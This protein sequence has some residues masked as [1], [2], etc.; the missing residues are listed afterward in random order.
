M[1]PYLSRLR[2]F[3]RDLRTCLR[4]FPDK[5]IRICYTREPN[6]QKLLNRR[7]NLKSLKHCNDK[8]CATC[9]VMRNT[10]VYHSTVTNQSS[11][12]DHEST[13]K[14]RSIVYLGT[15]DICGE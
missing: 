12:V 11:E 10:H 3:C 4:N 9:R 15:C 14:I 7:I 8:K 1:V 6:V 13:C 2:T 5:S